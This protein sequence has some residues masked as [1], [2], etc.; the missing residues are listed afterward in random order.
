[1]GNARRETDCEIDDVVF[2]EFSCDECIT[3]FQFI[4]NA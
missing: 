2:V 1:M 4:L 3:P